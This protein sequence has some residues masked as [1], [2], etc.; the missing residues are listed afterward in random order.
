MPPLFPCQFRRIAQNMAAEAPDLATERPT[1]SILRL[2]LPRET[3]IREGAPGT[4]A[5]RCAVELDMATN[6]NAG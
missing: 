3:A 4:T 2:R 5:S 6:G 1:P